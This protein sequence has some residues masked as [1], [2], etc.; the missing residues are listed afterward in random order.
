M[1]TTLDSTNKVESTGLVTTWSERYDDT[2][3]SAPFWEYN[4]IREKS[5]SYI[6]LTKAAAASGTASK[7]TQYTR[8]FKRWTWNGSRYVAQTA[9]T[10]S[11]VCAKIKPRHTGGR[12]WSVEID[13]D[14][15]IILY[16]PTRLSA[17]ARD[18]LAASVYGNWEY[19][20]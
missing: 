14:E 3:Q 2:T 12:L 6:G 17:S 11:A 18:S 9:N 15:E 16:S 20:E 8:T 4:R 1:L 7:T 5:Y 10:Y 19:D 13:V